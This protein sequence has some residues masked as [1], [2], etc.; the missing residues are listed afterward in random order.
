M[1]RVIVFLVALVVAASSATAGRAAGTAA[2]V[3]AAAAPTT[4]PALR[5]WA[6]SGAG[7]AFGAGARV[8]APPELAGTAGTFA[9][10]LRS[11]TGVPVGTSGGDARPGDLELRTGSARG[12]EEGYRLTV[13]STILLQG[14]TDRGVFLGTRTVLQLLKQSWV[15]P[16]GVAE[17]WPLYRERGFMVDVGRQYFS[18]DWLREHIRDMSYLK[19]NQLHLH[20]NDFTGFRLASRTHPEVVSAQHYTDQE[21]RDLIA[22]AAKYHVDV[23]P[24]LDFPG[25]MD[26]IL[27]A[28]PDLRLVSKTGAAHKS[29]I[30][31]SKPAAWTLMKDLIVEFLPLFPSEYWHI[32]ADEYVTDYADYPQLEA[33]AKARFGPNA[34]GKDVYH[35]YFN[36]ANA[37]VRGAGKTARAYNDGLKPGDATIAVD[38]DIVIE[39]WSQ[40]GPPPWFGPAYTGKQLIAMGYTVQNGSFTPTHHTA[41]GWAAPFNVPAPLM[42]DTWDPSV[43]VDGYRLSEAENR[44]NLGSKLKLWC[45]ESRQTEAQLAAAI[46]DKLRVMAQHT[47]RSPGPPLYLLFAP[48]ITAVGD[49]PA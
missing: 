6:V 41:G 28:H 48:V 25:H 18:L 43:F 42:Y 32:G 22:Y 34:T 15:V 1:R 2:G 26:P 24:E 45:D 19:M 17:D 20:F 46:H 33:Y 31:L 35:H 11:L 37:I 23:I 9:A 40:S 38:K 8:V 10:D 7:F 14:N 27:A 12:G 21:I 4:I 47:W 36:W 5:H 16:G 30:D 29:N 39:H 13:G 44:S 49:A 3:G